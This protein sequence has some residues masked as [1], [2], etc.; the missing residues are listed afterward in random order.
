MPVPDRAPRWFPLGLLLAA[1]SAGCDPSVQF[2]SDDGRL[3]FATV[4]R[5][6]PMLAQDDLGADPRFLAGSVVS[7]D[8][9][10]F[11]RG[12]WD[13]ASCVEVLTED[14]EAALCLDTRI[15][16]DLVGEEDGDLIVPEGVTEVETRAGSCEGA[17]EGDTTTVHGVAPADVTLALVERGQDDWTSYLDFVADVEG[18]VMTQGAA[19]QQA[20]PPLAAGEP[21]RVVE[22]SV[23]LVLPLLRDPGGVPVAFDAGASRWEVVAG[24]PVFDMDEDG[25][26]I[27]EG[28]VPAPRVEVGAEDRL[29]LTWTLAGH[30]LEPVEVEGV[31]RDGVIDLSLGLLYVPATGDNGAS[32]GEG[33]NPDGYLAA[34]AL[35]HD[36][37]GR[38]LGSAPIR[39]E[40]SGDGL[41][42][43][44]S[45]TF[46]EGRSVAVFELRDAGGVDGRERCVQVRASLGALADERE[47]CFELPAPEGA[48][49]CRAGAPA[50]GWLWLPGLLAWVSR[51]RRS[52]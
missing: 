34:R 43:A 45:S 15:P 7:F 46:D 21:W 27:T 8:L 2:A 17:A 3:R 22:G 52:R 29:A 10:R 40:A 49:T 38:P 36:A 32:D 19:Q 30:E 44:E 33:G 6:P 42:F 47:L 14:D 11:C 12:G 18:S 31:S 5:A 51:R 26:P 4:G 25:A 13:E 35:T 39:F 41:S 23:P 20:P 48:C 16:P 28:I 37:Q 24:A 1:A 9:R 50:P